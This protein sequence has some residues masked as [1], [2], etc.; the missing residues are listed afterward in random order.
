MPE[1][2]VITNAFIGEW[3]WRHDGS[4]SNGDVIIKEEGELGHRCGWSGG[5]WRKLSHNM[6]ELKF[7]GIVHVMVLDPSGNNLI[8]IEPMRYP[9]SV[10]VR[11]PDEILL[12]EIG[13]K[14]IAT[15]KSQHSVNGGGTGREY[16]VNLID[17]GEE[18]WNKWYS[19]ESGQCWH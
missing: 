5:V 3:E 12:K 19:N 9:P 10:A 11:K 1:G 17:H 16:P 8:L 13:L 6:V 4:V 15:V 14:E 2:I 18:G 7:N